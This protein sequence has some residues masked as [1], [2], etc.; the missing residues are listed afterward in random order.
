[1]VAVIDPEAVTVTRLHRGNLEMLAQE[2]HFLFPE[3][4]D[5]SSP[6]TPWTNAPRTALV[7][8]ASREFAHIMAEGA[9]ATF[10]QLSLIHI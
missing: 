6:I 5:F 3:G 2:Q 9:L 1:M 4:L 8:G 10:P 7:D